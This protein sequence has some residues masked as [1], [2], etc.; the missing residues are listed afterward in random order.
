MSNARED[1]PD[2]ESPVKTTSFPFGMTALMFLRLCC[3]APFTI[4]CVAGDTILSDI[5][6]KYTR[7][8]DEESRVTQN[9]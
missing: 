8:K 4:I 9:D 1:F 7:I 5:K 6:E 3:L 2:P